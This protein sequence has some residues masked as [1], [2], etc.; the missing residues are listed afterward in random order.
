MP[1]YMI[2]YMYTHP[3]AGNRLLSN[4]KQASIPLYSIHYTQY[5]NDIIV[6]TKEK[7]GLVCVSVFLL[8]S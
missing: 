3:A 6:Y 1:M 8:W 4:G 7:I 2:T 5:T